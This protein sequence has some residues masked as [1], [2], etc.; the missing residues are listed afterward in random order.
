MAL[1]ADRFTPYI[2]FYD[3]YFALKRNLILKI[4]KNLC[5]KQ[6]LILDCACGLGVDS[7][8]ISRIGHNVIS[9]DLSYKRVLLGRNLFKS[10]EFLVGDIMH[11][12]FRDG[13]FDCILSSE[14]L[15]HISDDVLALK[16]LSRTLKRKGILII[17][18]PYG[19]KLTNFDTRAGHFRRYTVPLL[20]RKV[21]YDMKILEVAYFGAIH[22]FLTLSDTFLHY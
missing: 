20:R 5:N 8:A 2:H 6:C 10:P 11:L 9:V 13:I 15:E 3:I 16:N 17:T 1:S 19:S 7:S 14:T 12:P 4:I 18:V 21:G 22:I